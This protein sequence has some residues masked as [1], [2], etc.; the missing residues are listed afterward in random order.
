MGMGM[1]PPPS[2]FIAVS[3][4][5]YAEFAKRMGLMQMGT[6]L[7]VQGNVIG[8]RTNKRFYV[9]PDVYRALFRNS[10][11]AGSVANDA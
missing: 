3:A 9:Q 5:R 11:P 6:H 8:W 2:G 7:S 10:S 1:G 4:R